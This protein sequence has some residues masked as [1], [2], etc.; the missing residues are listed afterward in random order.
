MFHPIERRH[1]A[2]GNPDAIRTA[3]GWV[4]FGSVPSSCFP[5]ELEPMVYP[6]MNVEQ[7]RQHG[8]DASSPPNEHEFACELEGPSSREDRRA[9]QMM[10][11]SIQLVD[12]RFQLPLLWRQENV[13]L[14]D[15]RSMA[16]HRLQALKK[17]LLKDK[18]L[19]GRYS[20]VMQTY[21]DK[22]YVE[23]LTERKEVEDSKSWFL[24]HH[25]VLL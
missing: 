21:L 15:N 5:E 6:C 17:R 19:H 8:M 7:K 1:G 10:K 24:V 23:A 20:E 14:P 2:R 11:E 9:Y 16:D 22:G 13:E 4:L 12:G 18:E 25:P 3:F